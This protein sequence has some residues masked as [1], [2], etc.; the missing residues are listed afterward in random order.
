MAC[1]S[2]I[3]KGRVS[4]FLVF[5][6]SRFTINSFDPSF[7]SR[8]KIIF[9]NE[10]TLWK[11]SNSCS[12]TF[13][14]FV[15]NSTLLHGGASVHLDSRFIQTSCLWFIQTQ[16]QHPVHL[17][18]F[19][20]SSSSRF[21]IPLVH[22]DFIPLV[23]LDSNSYIRFIQNFFIPPLHL[24]SSYLWFIQTSYL[25]LIQT[26]IHISGSSRLHTF[27]SSRLK[28]IHLVHLDFIPS[29]HLD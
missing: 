23:H 6:S 26:E 12:I 3:A 21:I 16:I 29:P 22:L 8:F 18:F 13:E 20:T 2:S 11:N 24:D 10:C 17:E 27:T 4:Y 15:Y 19:H 28:F 25:H 9:L 5:G 14:D 1:Q 7:G